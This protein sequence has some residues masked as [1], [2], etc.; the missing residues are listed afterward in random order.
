VRPPSRP[1]ALLLICLLGCGRDEAPPPI[2]PP[3][4]P[5][6]AA[7]AEVPPPAAPVVIPAQAPDGTKVE[8]Q[9]T[10][11][12]QEPAGLPEDLPLY[13]GAIPISSM[14]SPARGTIVN[15]RTTDPAASVFGWY[16][17]ELP[18]H[19][20][21]VERQSGAGGQHLVTAVKAGRKVTVLITTGAAGTQ[22]LLTVLENH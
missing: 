17:A 10:G 11:E 12:Q 5:E 18:K 9:Y 1:A 14:A 20:W 22:L 7:P 16:Q 19:G 6:R 4:A 3:P 2:A 13:A 21:I 8:S 15:L